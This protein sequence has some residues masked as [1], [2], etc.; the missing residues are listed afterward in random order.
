MRVRVRSRA[1]LLHSLY[2]CWDTQVERETVY[3]MTPTN[4]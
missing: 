4:R 2:C 3:Y 1:L